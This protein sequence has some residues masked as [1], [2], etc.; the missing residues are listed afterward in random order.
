MTADLIYI[1][2]EGPQCESCNGLFWQ[3]GPHLQMCCLLF[4]CRNCH[5]KYCTDHIC[6]AC[7][8]ER[9]LTLYLPVKHVK[10]KLEFD[11]DYQEK[12]EEKTAIWKIACD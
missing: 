7:K 2:K 10:T 3:D 11:L 5:L 12:E 8:S 6:P 4:I 9:D 1:M